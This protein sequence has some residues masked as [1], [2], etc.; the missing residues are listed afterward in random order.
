MRNLK[1]NFLLMFSLSILLFGCSNENE[2]IP[3]SLLSEQTSFEEVNPDFQNEIESRGPTGPLI[4]NPCGGPYRILTT[5]SQ[6]HCECI[7]GTIWEN[8]ICYFCW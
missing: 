8:G 1:F 5:D 7:F 4:S 3:D 6:T 2:I